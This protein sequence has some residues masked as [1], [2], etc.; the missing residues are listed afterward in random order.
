MSR[1]MSCARPVV[2]CESGVKV[3]LFVCVCEHVCE[4]F[5]RRVFDSKDEGT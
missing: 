5:L 4:R 1:P 2:M 3:Q